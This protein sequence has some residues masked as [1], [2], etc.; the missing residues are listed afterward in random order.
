MF[1]KDLRENE[2]GQKVLPISI[3][4]LLISAVITIPLAVAQEE[5]IEY[6]LCGPL[7]I[8]VN[9]TCVPDY[10]TVCSQ[11]TVVVDGMCHGYGPPIPSPGSCLIA[12]ASYGSELAPQVQILRE[13]R[14]NILLNTYSGT[15]F[16]DA[17]NSVYYSFSPHVA[18]L[19]NENPVFKEAVRTFITPL[20]STLSV[21]TMANEGSE[22]EVIFF[23]ISTIGL[24]VGMYIVT[25]VI[26]VWQ[27]RKRI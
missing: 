11:G 5:V 14:D 27:V 4:F 23:G 20:I 9:G 25:P 2:N 16:M 18:Q 24:I 17:F 15:L 12:T 8:D 7:T 1:L 21:M 3:V 26:V 13:I 10:E 22:S 6:G 19:E